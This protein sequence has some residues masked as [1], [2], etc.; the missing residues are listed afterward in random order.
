MFGI[1]GAKGG[2]EDYKY[3]KVLD[4]AGSIWDA[5]T[6]AEFLAA[7]RKHL[8]GTKMAFAGLKKPDQFAVVLAHLKSLQ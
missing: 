2:G 8:P 5:D 6:L 1:R 7:P 4:Q 3:S